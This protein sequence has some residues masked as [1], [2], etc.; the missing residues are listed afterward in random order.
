MILVKIGLW[1]DLGMKK[2]RSLNA[3]LEYSVG[4]LN[5]NYL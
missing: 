2:G 4:N 1:D 3:F 5:I